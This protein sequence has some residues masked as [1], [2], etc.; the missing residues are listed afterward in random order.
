MPLTIEK[1]GFPI[2]V[3]G[4]TATDETVIDNTD[5]RN[6]GS[7][8]ISHIYW[9]KPTTAGHLLSVKASTGKE[10]CK[11]VCEASNQSV[12]IPILAQFYDIVID[13]M[14]SGEVQ[15]FMG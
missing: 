3:T 15:I 13:D 8:R 7:P 9:Y 12:I 4:T 6:A 1:L 2:K 11:A 5:L 14:D 10:I